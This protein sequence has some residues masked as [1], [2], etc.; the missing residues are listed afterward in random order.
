M[1]HTHAIPDA[2]AL[3]DAL[4]D[5]GRHLHLDMPEADLTARF[6][7]V[8]G[9][10]LPGRALAVRV[11]D[12]R[13]AEPARAYA[14]GAELRAG[15]GDEPITMRESAIAGSGMK[16]AV[17]AS[18]RVRIAPRWDS[19]FHH[20][21]AGFAV[22]L[23]AAGELF[24]ALDVGHVHADDDAA[25]ALDEKLVLPLANQLA[26]ALRG[27]Q[28]FRESVRLRDFTAG[29]IEHANALIVGIDPR[30]RI[31]VCNRAMLELTGFSRD[32]VLG[33]DVRDF[34]PKDQRTRLTRAF[35]AALRGDSQVGVD[36]LLDTRSGARIRTLWS[37][38]AIGGGRGDLGGVEAVVGIGQDHSRLE[39]L[40]KQVVQSER[41][42]TLGQLA[43][44]VV[45]ELN[46]PLTSITVYADYLLG[47]AAADWPEGDREKLRRILSSAQRILNFT[48]ELVQ[49][50][51]PVGTELDAIDVN[52]VV[53][54]AA[55]FCEHL[56]ER[57]AIELRIDLAAELPPLHA[58]PGQLEQVLINLVTN[59]AH[60]VE[61]GGAIVI[62][63][64]ARHREVLIEV[65]DTGP[66]IPESE[67]DR[68]FEPFYTTKTDGKGTGLG[69]SIVKNI[70]EQHQGAVLI[71]SAAEGGASFTVILPTE[72]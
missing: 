19:P 51:K 50:A 3:A 65:A 33:R 43:A 63:T 66:G 69:L 8:V 40:Q 6:L 23:V 2:A 46:N 58:V 18:A 12:P 35:G 59:A 47:K 9:R 71:G 25:M 20:V 10:L 28:L 67:R 56:F 41:L 27:H 54:Q 14:V 21:A 68:V 39:D 22:P 42:A 55:S 29:L 53:R 7:A 16:S 26:V 72:L 34:L 38:A 1:M 36:V 15:I 32:Q 30:W 62:R 60:A 48:R 70:V 13:T 24:G 5:L 31:T 17:A 61:Q 49:Y 57:A 37:L 64:R 11:L 45:H 44:G 52:D 4:L